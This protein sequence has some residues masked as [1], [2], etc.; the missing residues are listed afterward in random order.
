M[1]CR[2]VLFDADSFCFEAVQAAQAADTAP[3]SIKA[4]RPFAAAAE[5]EEVA[6]VLRE[7]TAEPGT[8]LSPEPERASWE[9]H[10]KTGLLW[11]VQMK[12]PETQAEHLPSARC[13]LLCIDLH[14]HTANALLP[15]LLDLACRNGLYL[16]D[17]QKPDR[18]LWS[19]NRPGHTKPFRRHKRSRELVFLLEHGMKGL[20]NIVKIADWNSCPAEAKELR[21]HVHTAYAIVLSSRRKKEPRNL[22]QKAEELCAIL[23]D[24]LLPEEM[25]TFHDRFFRIVSERNGYEIAFCLEAYGKNPSM[26]VHMDSMEPVLH[27][28]IPGDVAE[29]PL[30]RPG[31]LKLKRRAG[32]YFSQGPD[33]SPIIRRMALG[34]MVY[35]FPDPGLRFAACVRMEKR[36]RY[37]GWGLGYNAGAMPVG[38][39]VALEDVSCRTVG[40]K[41]ENAG[42]LVME[43]KLFVLLLPVINVCAFKGRRSCSSVNMLSPMQCT[44]IAGKL[45]RLAWLMNHEPDAPELDAYLKEVSL[46][47]AALREKPA[48]E[49]NT[50]DL[51]KVGLHKHRKKLCAFLSFMIDWF[52]ARGGNVPSL[53]RGVNIRGL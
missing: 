23:T 13:R 1:L 50:T 33:H 24:A 26:T 44:L 32:E 27:P 17:L 39:L 29:V 22:K 25:L 53:D 34:D 7:A 14:R 15:P 47:A 19:P 10:A 2:L 21:R 6:A 30:G 52:S 36:F 8:M 49:E 9:F 28:D 3:G 35:R 45:K 46:N 37:V 16:A 40:D 38:T 41:R 20:R 42:T 4:L 31:T 12:A 48:Y 43:K 11:R 18:P 51:P 5:G